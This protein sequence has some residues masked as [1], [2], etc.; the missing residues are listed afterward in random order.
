[1]CPWHDERQI[2]RY[3]VSASNTMVTASIQAR[4][5]ST[6]LPG[7][8]L[9]SIENRRTIDLVRQRYKATSSVDNIVFTIGDESPN[10]AIIEWCN[11]NG[12]RY[13]VGPEEDLLARHRLSL[14]QTGDGTLVRGTGDCPFVPPSEID[15]LVDH[16]AGNG[17]TYTSNATDRMPV[18]TAVDVLDRSVLRELAEQ[19]E[20]HPA[21]PLRESP[22]EWGSVI[23]GSPAW[24]ELGAAHTAVD[25]PADYWALV[26]AVRAVG[27]DPREVTEWVAENR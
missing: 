25:T 5:G 3:V 13:V 18:G 11:R 17:E 19:G 6:R 27:F 7:K 14:D 24:A 12:H 22:D 20:T 23:D 26:D 21:V 10:E 8:V 9:L 16:H 15:R 4:M 1:M 2:D